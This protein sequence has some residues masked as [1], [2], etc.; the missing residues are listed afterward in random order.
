MEFFFGGTMLY[1]IALALLAT[2]LPMRL[3]AEELR[4]GTI[5]P[6]LTAP[7]TAAEVVLGKWLAA[8][9]S[10]RRA[11][12]PTLLYLVYLRAIGRVARSGADR[13]G[14]PGH[15]AARRGGAGG[16]AAGVGADAQPA[17]RGD[18]VVRRV[19]RRAAGRRAGGAG[20][21]AGAG[22]RASAAL[23]LFRMMEDFGHGIVDSRHVVLLVTV[24]VVALLAATVRGRRGC[25]GRSPSDAPRA[26]RA[27][28]LAGAR[29]LVAA[30]AR[31]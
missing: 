24:T 9:A 8:L 14:L 27:A 25:A 5:E 15:A 12:A 10:S 6:L 7:V 31:A 30:I 21:V 29:S 26:R 17:R 20:A 13:G 22:R 16:R 19:L 3:L 4:T 1:W 18:A 2:V 11:W 23:S 28:G